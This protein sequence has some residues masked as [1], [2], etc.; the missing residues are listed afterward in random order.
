MYR[1]CKYW[2]NNID[3]ID[4]ILKY[5]TLEDDWK[6]LCDSLDINIKLSYKN[7]TKD[8]LNYR[9]YYNNTTK[10]IIQ[11]YFNDDIELFN[12]TF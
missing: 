3:N 5:E 2:L 4:C 10:N 7:K 8:K 11:E 6:K 1:P 12:Y 9:E